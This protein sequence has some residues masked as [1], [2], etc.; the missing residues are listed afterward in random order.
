[1][2]DLINGLLMQTQS[3]REPWKQNFV[4]D[5]VVIAFTVVVLLLTALWA[6]SGRTK[7]E[8]KIP[9]ERTAEDF[10]G[11]VQ[12]AYGPIPPFLLALY[13][14]VLL[15]IAGYVIVAIVNGTQY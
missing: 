15:V 14:I 2:I 3:V 5:G 12:A 13:A 11:Q 6:W 8:R 10:A 9:F 4:V 7:K 1:M